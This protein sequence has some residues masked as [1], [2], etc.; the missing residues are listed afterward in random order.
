MTENVND[1]LADV[2]EKRNI[3]LLTAEDRFELVRKLS[4]DVVVLVSAGETNM[5]PSVIGQFAAIV[6]SDTLRR[7]L[8]DM[9]AEQAMEICEKLLAEGTLPPGF[10]PG[11]Q[12]PAEA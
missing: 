10:N 2:A 12:P 6:A 7:V 11:D 4:S 8:Q 1:V 3:P 9:P 5:I